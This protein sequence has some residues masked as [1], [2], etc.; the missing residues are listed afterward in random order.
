MRPRPVLAALAA[1]VLLA[2]GCH[3]DKGSGGG[4]AAP[5]PV[6]RPSEILITI[7]SMAPRRITPFGGTIAM[8]KL[9]ELAA[10]GTI[11][12]DAVSCTT[13]ARPALVTIMTG[14]ATDRSGVRDNIHDALPA[15]L[16]SL[17]ERAKAAGFE[18]AAFVSTPFA[19]YAS[20]LQRGFDLFDGPEAVVVGPVQHNPPVTSA[21]KVAAHFGE[22]LASRDASKPYFV[23]IHLADLSGAS[24]PLDLQKVKMQGA[25]DTDFPLYDGKL[26][27]VDAAIGAVR[28]A[29]GKSGGTPSWT[30]VGTQGTYLGEGGRFGEAFWL[31]D[32][33]LR[34]P[35]VRIEPAGAGGKK[36]SRPTWLPDVAATLAQDLHVA[37]DSRAEGVP[38][39]TAPPHD[40][41]RFA[42]NYAV[43]DELG[44]P[45]EVATREGGQFKVGSAGAAARPAVARA[46]N[47]PPAARE[48]IAHA[49]L[50]VGKDYVPVA[51]GG[52]S[53]AFLRNLQL[54][55]RFLNVNRPKLAARHSRDMLQQSP[56]ALAA[57]ITRAFF[58]SSAPG[59]EGPAILDK[60]LKL[61]PNRSDALHWA[62][63]LELVQKRYEQAA[64]LLDA[65][66]AVGPVEPEMHYDLAC[67][68]SS[69]GDV[70]G[71]LAALDHALGAGYRNWDWIDKDPDLAAVRADRGFPAL[72]R[73]HGR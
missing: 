62:A 43:D 26:A 44:W 11:F 19:S 32:E 46:R 8:P 14:V 70:A 28:D 24:V 49:G 17:A 30:I 47:L 73:T 13:L 34:V 27:V 66:I 22:W 3:G 39:A 37:L 20:G 21:D 35:L 38:L 67:V 45:P 41:V 56:D 51:A 53:E 61:Y 25:P 50:T 1:L 9:A 29:V 52:S 68:R 72:L 6:A 71:A 63:H 5:A 65:A 18:T 58:F 12:E 40:R 15:D 7:E 48:A 42:W 23:W 2:A 4:T 36:D 57:L 54:V 33:T 16:S 64:A 69:R 59:G 55:R 10:T 60:F 31:A